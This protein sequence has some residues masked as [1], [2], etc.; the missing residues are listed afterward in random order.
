MVDKLPFLQTKAP[1][2]VN[3]SGE[4]A[5]LLPGSPSVLSY[6]GA[7]N[8]TS[9][10]DDF[11]NSQ[12]VIDV[13]AANAWQLSGT[14][15]LFPEASLFNNLAYGYNRA[16]LAFYNIDPIFY[17]SGSIPVSRTQLSNHYVRQIFQTAA[18]RSNLG[19]GILSKRAWTL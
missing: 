16:R 8:G 2:S 9:Y 15:R 5:Q 12:S 13:K 1:S 14:P 7:R 4:F 11:E 6:A 10:L 3:F 19:Y 18:G 17:T